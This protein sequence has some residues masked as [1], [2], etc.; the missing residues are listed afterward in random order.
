MSDYF[1]TE[2]LESWLENEVFHNAVIPPEVV[3]KFEKWRTNIESSISAW[4]ES[5]DGNGNNLSW[6]A[7]GRGYAN[8]PD[9]DEDE[10]LAVIKH[11]NA[12]I[13]NLQ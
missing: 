9:E 1:G 11:C 10:L 2:T 13:V 7:W 8:I 5:D 3:S 6:R 12:V 4:L